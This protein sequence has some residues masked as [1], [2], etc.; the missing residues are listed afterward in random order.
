MID[1]QFIE[2]F[3]KKKYNTTTDK[4]FRV[5]R[6]VLSIWRNDKFPVGR[7]EE[8]IKKEGNNNIIQLF[9]EIYKIEG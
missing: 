1:L 9:S 5:S 4:Y 7:L 3:I 8:F 6:P 2:F